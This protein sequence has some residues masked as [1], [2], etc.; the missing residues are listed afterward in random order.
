MQCHGLELIFS[1]NKTEESWRESI[2]M[3]MWRGAPLLQGEVEIIHDY[4]VSD[5]GRNLTPSS[6]ANSVTVDTALPEGPGKALVAAACV[7][8]HDFSPIFSERRTSEQ[9]RVIVDEMVRLGSPLEASE[10]DIVIDYLAT[11]VGP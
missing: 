5:Y 9:W 11:G 2:V 1:Q 4:L 10:S 3:M 6:S 8:C 7:G